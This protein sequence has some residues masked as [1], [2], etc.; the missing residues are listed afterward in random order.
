MIGGR[1]AVVCSTMYYFLKLKLIL[2]VVHH[3]VPQDI[4]R[5]WSVKH[6]LTIEK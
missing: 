3:L 1:N 2:Q 6:A 5:E 4:R